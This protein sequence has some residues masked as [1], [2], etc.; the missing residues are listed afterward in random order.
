LSGSKGG[1]LQ[2]RPSTRALTDHA[3]AG[4]NVSHTH[5]LNGIDILKSSLL[6]RGKTSNKS[7]RV[8]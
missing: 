4:C 1:K 7:V 5:A 6:G 2:L 3:L 8:F